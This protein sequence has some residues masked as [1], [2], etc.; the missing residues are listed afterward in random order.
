MTLKE[1]EEIRKTISELRR[2]LHDMLFK[3]DGVEKLLEE[4]SPAYHEY[5]ELIRELKKFIKP[6]QTH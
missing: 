1:S 3:A 6:S 4:R 5:S 2:M